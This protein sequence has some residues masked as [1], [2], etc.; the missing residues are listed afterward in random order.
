MYLLILNFIIGVCVHFY[1]IDILHT[2][3]KWEKGEN[4]KGISEQESKCQY[5]L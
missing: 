2:T 5:C 3:Q 4:N 1:E